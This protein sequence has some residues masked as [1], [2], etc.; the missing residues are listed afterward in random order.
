MLIL[1]FQDDRENGLWST[2]G[3]LKDHYLLDNSEYTGDPI[4]S[5]CVCD[6]ALEVVISCAGSTV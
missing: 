5:G 6:D 4:C 1:L 2:D 3:T